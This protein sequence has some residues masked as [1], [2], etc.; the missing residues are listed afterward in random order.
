MD[1]GKIDLGLS[2]LEGI[3]GVIKNKIF[4]FRALPALQIGE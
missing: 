3:L 1:L 2:L 4:L